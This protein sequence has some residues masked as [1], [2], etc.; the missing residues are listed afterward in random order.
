MHLVLR[1]VVMARSPFQNF[2]DYYID[3]LCKK[4][5]LSS[6]NIRQISPA[7]FVDIAQIHHRG[8][9]AVIKE[10]GIRSFIAYFVISS[11]ISARATGRPPS[12]TSRQQA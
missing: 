8:L 12:Y 6:P 9:M 1:M 5:A 3:T 4:Q 10:R 7:G 2:L 11:S